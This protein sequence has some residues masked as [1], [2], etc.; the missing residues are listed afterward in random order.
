LTP[1]RSATCSQ[2]GAY[3]EQITSA[4][5]NPE[6][7]GGKGQRHWRGDGTNVSSG[8]TRITFAAPQDEVWI[9]WYGRYQA[10]FRWRNLLYT[11]TMIRLDNNTLFQ[12]AGW[13]RLNVY[14]GGSSHLS[15]TGGW[16]TVMRNGAID[17]GTGHRRSDGRFHR[18]E[19]HLKNNGSNGI[20]E[21]WVDG[22]RYLSYSNV[23]F[24]TDFSY[25]IL[26]GAGITP[27][28]GGCF[29]FDF[30]DIAVSATGSIGP[31]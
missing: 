4:A 13:N 28:N 6:G 26:S 27:S 7:G 17:A 10:D 21:A 12:F 19:L 2:G 5:N 29:Y 24:G 9:R 8:G 18:Y 23:N 11:D 3:Y 31:P 25:L 22:V 20:A 16:D 1:Y 30:D 14:A 15:S